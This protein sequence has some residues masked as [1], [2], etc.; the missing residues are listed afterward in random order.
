MNSF[1]KD[2]CLIWTP[3]CNCISSDYFILYIC[4]MVNHVNGIINMM[5]PLGFICSVIK[6]SGSRCKKIKTFIWPNSIINLLVTRP[7]IYAFCHR[8]CFVMNFANGFKFNA[9]SLL[10]IVSVTLTNYKGNWITFIEICLVL[11]YSNTTI[12]KIEYLIF[13][14]N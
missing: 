10:N 7:F 4:K 3:S 13:F 9:S 2:A 1:G 14:C 12:S 6:V 8:E 11:V 5:Q